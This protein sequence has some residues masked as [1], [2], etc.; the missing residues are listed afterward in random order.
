MIQN[1]IGVIIV[2]LALRGWVDGLST[3]ISSL[4]KLTEQEF[5]MLLDI[6]KLGCIN[7]LGVKNHHWGQHVVG[8]LEEV[9]NCQVLTC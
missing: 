5:L 8:I 7:L 3:G 9:I 1:F 2:R 6:V 4:A